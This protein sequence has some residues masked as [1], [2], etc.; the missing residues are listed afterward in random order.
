[1]SKKPKSPFYVDTLLYAKH[2]SASCAYT[3]PKIINKKEQLAIGLIYTALI[4]E[5]L[6]IHYDIFTKEKRKQFNH[7]F[8]PSDFYLNNFLVPSNIPLDV[9]KSYTQEHTVIH[10]PFYV[11]V[12]TNIIMNNLEEIYSWSHKIKALAYESSLPSDLID[13]DDAV[14]FFEERKA[15]LFGLES[16]FFKLCRNDKYLNSVKHKLEEIVFKSDK[17]YSSRYDDKKNKGLVGKLGN[18]LNKNL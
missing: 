8:L 5:K 17:V 12:M 1:M 14:N 11:F 15:N 2:L 9:D 10:N 7:Y 6:A 18:W 3:V 16:G 4:I 13:L